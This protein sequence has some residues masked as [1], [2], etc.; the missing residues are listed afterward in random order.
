MLQVVEVE[1][2]WK[3][4]WLCGPATG[5]AQLQWIETICCL[6]GCHA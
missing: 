5:T 4:D 6:L 1:N 2:W 3:T